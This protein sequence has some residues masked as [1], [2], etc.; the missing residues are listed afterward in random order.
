MSPRAAPSKSTH[1]RPQQRSGAQLPPSDTAL[2]R[3]AP[4]AERRRWYQTP[5]RPLAPSAMALSMSARVTGPTPEGRVSLAEGGQARVVRTL[6]THAGG[7]DAPPLLE[8][9]RALNGKN[10]LRPHPRERLA[11]DWRSP[12][13]AVHV[14]RARQHHPRFHDDLGSDVHVVPDPESVRDGTGGE[15]MPGVRLGEQSKDDVRVEQNLTHR[16]CERGP[17]LPAGGPARSG[18]ASRAHR[19][20]P[21]TPRQHV[22]L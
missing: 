4:A 8:D 18:G 6:P 14:E 12:A 7:H 20:M 19:A 15:L 17:S 9:G 11:C 1:P 2:R 3:P 13:V 16:R 21:R 22:A 5:P 10:E